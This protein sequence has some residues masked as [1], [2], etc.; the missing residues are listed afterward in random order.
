MI[1]KVISIINIIGFNSFKYCDF[2]VSLINLT[3]TFTNQTL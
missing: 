1:G 2:N 3:D